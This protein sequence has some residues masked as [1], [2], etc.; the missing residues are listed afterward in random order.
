MKLSSRLFK[1]TLLL[2]AGEAVAQISSLATNIILA[3]LLTRSDF[4]TA[5]LLAMNVSIFE[6]GG[7]LALENYLIQSE[8]GAD[9]RY[10]RVVHSF[11]AGFGV[12]SAVALAMS[13]PYVAAFF[14]APDVE[15]ALRVVAVVPLLKGLV[16][17]EPAVAIKEFRYGRS[18]AI[19]AAPQLMAAVLAWPLAMVWPTYGALALLLVLKQVVA[20]TASHCLARSTYRLGVDRA[21]SARLLAFGG[22]ML[23]SSLL[24]ML[25]FHGD[26]FAIGVRYSVSELGVYAVAGAMTLM[27]AAALH[28]LSGALLL[29]AMA[30]AKADHSHFVRRVGAA[31]EVLSLF[32]AAYA[33][34]MVMSGPVLATTIFGSRYSDSGVLISVLGIAQALRLLRAIP[35]VS[36]MAQGDSESLMTANAIRAAS[37]VLAFCLAWWGASL[38]GIAAAA[39]VGECLALAGATWRFTRVHRVPLQDFVRPVLAALISIVTASVLGGSEFAR[40]SFAAGA[41]LTVACLAVLAGAF[42]FWFPNTRKLTDCAG[43]VWP[44]GVARGARIWRFGRS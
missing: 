20:T 17:L 9:E 32:S 10:L 36:A 44:S 6:L 5:S 35:T 4:G 2:A 43:A 42:W 11:H 7:R 31:A 3:R 38:S 16:H 1:G 39:V 28:K 15:W 18:V 26:R 37:V 24:M 25:I 19:D 21:I 23:A 14:K 40:A 27:P 22:P 13:A 30:G 12:L 29:P 8:H 33:V 34:V 41:V